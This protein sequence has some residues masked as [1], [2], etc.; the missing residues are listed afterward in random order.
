MLTQYFPGP[1]KPSIPRRPQEARR[2]VRMHPVRLLLDILP[3]VLVEQR[4]IPRPGR[5]V[6]ILPLARRFT[7]RAQSR[8][9][10]DAG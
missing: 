1:R 10:R 9:E 3:V 6:A 4:R 7:R 8:E 2:A 5:A